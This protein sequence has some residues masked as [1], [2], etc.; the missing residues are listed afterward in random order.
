MAKF[1]ALPFFT[2]TVS[3]TTYTLHGY[4]SGLNLELN[5]DTV[6]V[7]NAGGAGWKEFI[8]GLK[9]ANLNVDLQND[10]A[11][12]TTYPAMLA[13][14]NAGSTGGTFEAR[15]TN[16][17]VSTTNPKFTGTLLCAKF[18]P[19]SGN[20]GTLSKLPAEVQVTGAVTIATS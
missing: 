17:A 10:F 12:N 14:F 7:T 15:A 6:D 1:V 9:S 20:V 2:L 5:Q 18:T 16:A 13:L 19:I 8:A 11:A 3:A 4:V